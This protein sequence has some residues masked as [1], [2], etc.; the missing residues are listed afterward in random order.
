MLCC[1]ALCVPVRGGY[2]CCVLLGCSVVL[3]NTMPAHHKHV[4]MGRDQVSTRYPSTHHKCNAEDCQAATNTCPAHH[5]NGNPEELS[6]TLLCVGL[7]S[8]V[9]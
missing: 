2:M 8:V 6:Y 5:Q 4:M 9:M 3:T 1:V 7:C